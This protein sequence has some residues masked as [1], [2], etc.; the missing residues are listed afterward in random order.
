[1]VSL[2]RMQREGQ[3]EGRAGSVVVVYARKLLPSWF[4]IPSPEGGEKTGVSEAQGDATQRGRDE[5]HRL[6]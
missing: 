3:G 5:A 6:L 4:R 1:M 2:E